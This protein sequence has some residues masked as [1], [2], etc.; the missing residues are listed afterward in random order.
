MIV[1]GDREKMPETTLATE[2][3]GREIKERIQSIVVAPDQCGF[4]VYIL[5][6]SNFAL[7]KMGFFED[8]PNILRKK[9]KE[10]I[11][12]CLEDK[13]SAESTEYVPGDYIADSQDKI[14]I[15]PTGEGYDPFKYLTLDN[16][17]TFSKAVQW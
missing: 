15:I 5:S 8:G 1:K 16:Q 7:K 3:T 12:K 17:G 2:L 13:F 9:L 10:N 14:Y 11:L 4:E 6:K